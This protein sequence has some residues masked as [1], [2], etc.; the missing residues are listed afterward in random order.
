MS[1]RV[2]FI[3]GLL[4]PAIAV[5]ALLVSLGSFFGF[6]AL[7]PANYISML[8]LLLISLALSDLVLIHRR[9]VEIDE[10]LQHLVM[11]IALEHI[12][13]EVIERIDP[14]LLKVLKDDY[15][16]DVV[17]F[18][19]TAINESKVQVNDNVRLR[20]YYIRTLESYPRATF[21]SARFSAAP[22]HE[23][24]R[25]EKALATFTA[26]GGKMKHI[27]IVKDTQELSSPTIQAKAACLRQTGVQ[28]HLVNGSTLPVDLRKNFLVESH[29]KIAWEMQVDHEG[30]VTSGMV[31]TNRQLNRRYCHIFEKLLENE[32]HP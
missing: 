16:L 6:L 21:L 4:P 20:Y 19:L 7:I 29:G 15:F 10:R 14:A 9:M 23:N 2:K 17:T 31:S 28:V 1:E 12:S 11:K 30:H 13:G 5:I 18:L 22:R 25:I 3:E 27:I 24:H 32:I 8:P 26:K